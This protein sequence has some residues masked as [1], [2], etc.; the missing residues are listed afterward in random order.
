MKSLKAT[1][2]ICIFLLIYSPSHSQTMIPMLIYLSPANHHQISLK[3]NNQIR[4]LKK[5]TKWKQ[6]TIA[7]RFD[8]YVFYFSCGSSVIVTDDESGDRLLMFLFF[9]FFSFS[10]FSGYI[11]SCVFQHFYGIFYEAQKL[12]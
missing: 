12:M 4:L 10:A 8:V 1:Q 2:M 11:C 9:V 7:N 3:K 6:F 5:L